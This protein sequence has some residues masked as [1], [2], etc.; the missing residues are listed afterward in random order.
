MGL[1]PDEKR[2]GYYHVSFMD[3]SDR[4]W[5]NACTTRSYIALGVRFKNTSME[6]TEYLMIGYVGQYRAEPNVLHSFLGEHAEFKGS[7]VITWST[8]SKR[9]TEEVKEMIPR[10]FPEAKDSNPSFED[11][12]GI[13]LPNVTDAAVL[14]GSLSS[15][16]NAMKTPG[17][18]SSV[19]IHG[20]DGTPIGAPKTT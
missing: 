15:L 16:F 6:L 14:Y 10:L 11:C 5:H 12:N 20:D 1:I 4:N 18:S 17:D 7:C 9:V 13:R 2:Q 3:F 19:Q 8:S